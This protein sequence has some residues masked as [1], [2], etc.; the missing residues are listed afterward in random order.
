MLEPILPLLPLDQYGKNYFVLMLKCEGDNADTS[1]WEGYK[2]ILKK[3]CVL[4]C[5][6]QEGCMNKI[7]YKKSAKNWRVADEKIT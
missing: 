6:H 2:V 4:Q 5:C 1:L 3:G 7:W